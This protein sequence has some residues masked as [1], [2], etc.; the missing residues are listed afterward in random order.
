MRL[1]VI[2]IDDKLLL[3]QDP[4]LPQDIVEMTESLVFHVDNAFKAGFDFAERIYDYET[5]YFGTLPNLEEYKKLM[6]YEE[7]T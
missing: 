1:R 2:D 6:G 7:S 4:I 3:A 5:T